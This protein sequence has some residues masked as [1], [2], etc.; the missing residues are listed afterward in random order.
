[1]ARDLT[2]GVITAIDEDFI[3]PIF[4]TKIDTSGGLLRLW[5]GLGTLEFN[6][7]DYLG[8]G[9][10]GKLSDF[11]ETS[12]LRANGITLSLSGVS[13][14]MLSIAL[15]QIQQGRDAIVFMGFFDNATRTLII[16][17]YEIFT[18]VTDIPIIKEGSSRA[19]IAIKCENRLV[20]LN[21]P[22][23]RRYTKEDQS[24]EFPSDLGFDF[25][26]SIQDKIIEF[27]SA[28]NAAAQADL[29]AQTS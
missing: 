4:L 14:D 26:P 19:T 8:I 20:T 15:S 5:N 3:L 6:S 7:E 24:I 16:D 10:G 13:Q 9:K 25:V 23:V 28:I 12:D 1:M 27:G 2:A 11:Q 18:G 22:K 29:I 21:T 17:P